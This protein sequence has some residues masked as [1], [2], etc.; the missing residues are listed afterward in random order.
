MTALVSRSAVLVVPTS[1]AC[2]FDASATID[3]GSC[4]SLSCAGCTDSAACNFDASAT[5]DDG[6]CESLSCAGCTD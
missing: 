2:N 1:A 3:D 6:S 5:I 4:E